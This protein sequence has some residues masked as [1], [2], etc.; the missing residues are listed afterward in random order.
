MYRTNAFLKIKKPWWKFW[1]RAENQIQSETTNFV[2]DEF[3]AD[4][5]RKIRDEGSSTIASSKEM[6]NALEQAKQ[7]IVTAAKDGKSQVEYEPFKYDVQPIKRSVFI[8]KIRQ[9][10]FEFEVI[11]DKDMIKW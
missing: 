9:L 1:V 10:G 6:I 8:S 2:L 3:N 5:V 7:L 11:R 4:G